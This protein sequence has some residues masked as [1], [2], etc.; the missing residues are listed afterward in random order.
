MIEHKDTVRLSG[1]LVFTALL[2][3]TE[4]SNLS[5]ERTGTNT[6]KHCHHRTNLDKSLSRNEKM[7]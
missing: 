2:P 5:P 4:A 7:I 6:G 3:G 1:K